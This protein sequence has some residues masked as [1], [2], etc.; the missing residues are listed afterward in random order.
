MGQRLLRVQAAGL[1]EGRQGLPGVI[2]QPE[3]IAQV[4]VQTQVLGQVGQGLPVDRRCL[5]GL[6]P[7]L[8]AFRQVDRRRR[9]ERRC[10][11]LSI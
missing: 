10:Q 4:V 1:Q 7:L 3:A 8:E 5:Q 9:R 11:L 6:P 2:R